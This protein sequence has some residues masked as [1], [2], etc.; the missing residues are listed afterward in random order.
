MQA[1]KFDISIIRNVFDWKDKT[2]PF[3][4]RDHLTA[5]HTSYFPVLP[6]TFFHERMQLGFVQGQ[7][8]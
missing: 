1:L 7:K 5:N 2:I 8:P 3:V 4:N 6:I